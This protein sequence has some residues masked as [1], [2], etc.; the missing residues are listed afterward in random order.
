LDM[1]VA[2]SKVQMALQGENSLYRSLRLQ[3][4]VL[5]SLPVNG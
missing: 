5:I 2:I 1:A 3:V 4:F